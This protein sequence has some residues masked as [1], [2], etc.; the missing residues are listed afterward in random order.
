MH[1]IT[2]LEARGVVSVGVVTELFR[3]GA[4][5]QCRTLAF[6]PAVVYVAHPIQ[7][8]TDAELQQLAEDAFQAILRAVQASG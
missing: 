8:R 6:E 5:A 4:E 7:D 3:D 2:D 1:D